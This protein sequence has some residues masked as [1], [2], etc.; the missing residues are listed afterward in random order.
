M[1]PTLEP[2]PD[3]W[4]SPAEH[5]IFVE[6]WIVQALASRYREVHG[7]FEIPDNMMRVFE[8]VAV[9]ITAHQLAQGWIVPELGVSIE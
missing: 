2:P 9:E 8:D 6:G 4:L 7:V 1:N 3:H 5:L